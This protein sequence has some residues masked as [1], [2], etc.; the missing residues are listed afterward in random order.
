MWQIDAASFHPYWHM[1]IESIQS[2]T[3]NLNEQVL[4]AID[5]IREEW[6]IDSRVDIIELLLAELLI[7]ESTEALP[8]RS[9]DS[10]DG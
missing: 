9:V 8:P 10:K 5:K 2:I 1:K 3:I 6:G 4:E 7:P